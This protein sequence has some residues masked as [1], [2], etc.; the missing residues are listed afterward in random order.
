[1]EQD[2]SHNPRPHYV[3]AYVAEGSITCRDAYGTVV[4]EA[5]SIVF[6]PHRSCYQLR[7]NSDPKTTVFSCFFTFPAFSEPLE[8]RKFKIQRIDGEEALGADFLSLYG[9]LSEHGVSFRALSIFYKIASVLC[10]R[11]TALGTRTADA[12]ISA[13]IAY[14]DENHAEQIQV[15]QL[16]A[17]VHLSPSRFYHLFREEVGMSPIDYKN[18]VSVRAAEQLLREGK[19]SIEEI[20][21]AV[22]FASATY[23]RRVFR[24]INGQSP[25]EFRAGGAK[26]L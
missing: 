14:L 7:W 6:I 8:T 19:L 11:L 5:G 22:G 2:Y 18:L 21:F 9:E 23:F 16:A 4:G 26:G 12:R 20:G 17:L 25:R 1:M 24:E 15:E 10:P 3:F 13:A